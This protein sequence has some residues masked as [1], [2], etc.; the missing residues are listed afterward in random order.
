MS[1]IIYSI[2][3]AAG[4]GTRMKKPESQ[5]VL[6]KLSGKPIVSYTVETLKQI[7]NQKPIVIV[8]IESEKVKKLLGFS[9]QYVYQKNRLGTGHAVMQAK[10]KLKGKLGL[11]IVVNGDNPFFSCK[12]LKKLI[13]KQSKTKAKM[14]IVEAVLGQ[15]FPYG[16][17]IKDKK[18]GVIDIVEEKNCTSKQKKIKDKN[19]GCYIFDNQWLWQ[20]LRKLKK[21]NVTHEYYITDLAKIANSMG[22]RA[23]TIKL[24]QKNEAVGVNTIEDL[25]LAEKIINKK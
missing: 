1:K 18:G 19:C 4:H 23:Q 5:K 21:N 12:T 25:K 16:R 11:T 17:V 22:T 13:K 2:V 14:I 9:C 8:G 15:N 20:A 7:S 10:N 24:T 6:T 3:L